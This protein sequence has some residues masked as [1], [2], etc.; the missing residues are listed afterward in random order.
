MAAEALLVPG[1][2]RGQEDSPGQEGRPRVEARLRARAEAKQAELWRPVELRR[3][4]LRRL[5]QAEMQVWEAHR[6]RAGELRPRARRKRRW[7]R[8]DVLS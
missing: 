2:S 4:E 7:R 6:C 1:D 8:E 5:P 3:G